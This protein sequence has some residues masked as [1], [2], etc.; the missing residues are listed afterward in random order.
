MSRLNQNN[1]KPQRFNS[2]A[3]PKPRSNSNNTHQRTTLSSSSSSVMTP[4]HG[5]KIDSAD[6]DPLHNIST[7]FQSPNNLG[8]LD[9]LLSYTNR[10]K[11]RLE[12]DIIERQK[13]YNDYRLRSNASNTPNGNGNDNDDSQDL[14]NLDVIE[15]DLSKLIVDFEDAKNL[16]ET[17]GKTINDMT[18]NI[19]ILDNC[20][21]NLILSMTI[22]KRLQMLMTAY[23]SLN[24]MINDNKNPNKKYKE[25]N[26]LLSVVV[27]LM[28]H[29]QSYKSIDDINTLNKRIGSLKN[30]LIDE[31]FND[32]EKEFNNELK[33]PELVDACSILDT[34][35]KSYSDKLK[36][37]YIR[38]Q[39]REL[40]SI[41]KTTDEAGSLDNLKRRFVFFQG[42]LN[43][44]ERKHNANFPKD[45]E[46]SLN[47]SKQF[48]LLTKNDL[49]ELTAKETR[50]NGN[51]VD[52]NLLINS[53]MDTLEFESFLNQ[54]YKYYGDY[55][56]RKLK[57]SELSNGETLIYNFDKTISDVFEPYLNIWIDHQSDVISKKFIEYMNP[58]N[59]LLNSGEELATSDANKINDSSNHNDNNHS[60]TSHS[61]NN[62]NKENGSSSSNVLESSADLFRL[63]RSLLSQ[64]A[65][66]S[67]GEPLLRLSKVFVKYL[68]QYQIKILEPI[69]PDPKKLAS[70]T[71]ED[72]NEAILYICLVLNTA[73]YCSTTI[74]QLEDKLISLF[75]PPA[76]AERLPFDRVRDSYLKITNNCINL[77]F[78]KVQKDLSYSWRE[79]TNSNWKNLTEVIGES[80]YI[81]TMKSTINESCRKIFNKF[82]RSIYIRNFIDRL[83]E[84]IL[85]ELI[86]NINKLKPITEIMSEQFLLDLQT[87]KDFLIELP[88]LSFEQ[89]NLVNKNKSI[90][91]S[92]IYL[93]FLDSKFS[94]LEDL[95]KILMTDIKP[96]DN[97]ITNYF[98]IIGDTNF[99]NFINLV[100][101]KGCYNYPSSSSSSY[102]GRNSKLFDIP[103]KDRLK[104]L[105]QF[106]QQLRIYQ[107][108]N[109]NSES[110]TESNEF[111]ESNFS[112]FSSTTGVPSSGINSNRISSNN[113]SNNNYYSSHLGSLSK[114][115]TSFDSGNNTFDM[116][117][118]NHGGTIATTT[119]GNTNSNNNNNSSN[120]GTP[121][122]FQNI[123]N[124]TN[125]ESVASSPI[126][127]VESII[128]NFNGSN[129]NNN[130]NNDDS[131]GTGSNS[132][133][134]PSTNAFGNFLKESMSSSSSP[135]LDDNNNNNGAS[136]LG[137]KLDRQSIFNT[138]ENL[139]KSLI[140]A[141]TKININ[142]N[143]KN[144]G[145]FF[146]KKN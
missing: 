16:A 138:R 62:S 139:A 104:Y 4:R 90:S 127:H 77:L 87:L 44:F 73:D 135:K 106:K 131:T 58:K 39:L 93:K 47:L 51:K 18:S 24:L 92:T 36:N 30:K 46:M 146:S 48:C 15:N 37:W 38:R 142:E 72:N 7:I 107:D 143:F 45:W 52:V 118:S 43:N 69:L 22:L 125:L 80:R 28:Q 40:T 54:K 126:A 68:L 85:N 6:Y 103:D 17:T 63:Y 32:F 124:N 121:N 134:T 81:T 105:D 3:V 75:E 79:L 84:Y 123:F 83:T 102:S 65:K 61:N 21:K 145:K 109:E 110:L 1:G 88:N 122:M 141:E 97:F 8:D 56:D 120:A 34:L 114:N 25:I 99:A 94:K 55:D 23:D 108:T 41:F 50:F 26:Q 13:R 132:P 20:K 128:S 133:I 31:I 119:N 11:L 53:L 27:E 70:S 95:F 117:T 10:Y 19:K 111:I 82:N 9:Q 89:K 64:L 86:N 100:K 57:K 91:K 136:A 67:H 98:I 2:L 76:L 33:N 66:L 101:L 71:Q 115:D 137:F 42:V 60:N 140:N 144:F 112:S 12:Q 116:D 14:T 49:K 129:N 78:Y 130:N 29:F 5:N 35:G 74:T 113:N 59:L 96:I